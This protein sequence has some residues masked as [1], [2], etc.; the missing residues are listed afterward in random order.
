MN[1]SEGHAI[2]ATYWN[3]C[4]T[5]WALGRLSHTVP[6][7]FQTKASASRRSTSTPRFAMKSISS[8]IA[9]NT[10]GLE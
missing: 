2:R 4:I 10:S 7:S 9:R 6:F 3:A 1:W 8:H 5:V